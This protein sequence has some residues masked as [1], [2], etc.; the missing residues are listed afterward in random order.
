MN[1]PGAD[2][3]QGF[4][5]SQKGPLVPGVCSGG[6]VYEEG[7]TLAAL[8]ML[9]LMQRQQWA[10]AAENKQSTK[11]WPGL[12]C[13]LEIGSDITSIPPKEL[14]P[15]FIV[16]SW[17]GFCMWKHTGIPEQ[18]FTQNW[19]WNPH[20]GALHATARILPNP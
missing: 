2:C 10:D 9:Q 5:R 15:G 1:K 18:H 12:S 11:P 8:L 6:P 4:L 7:I 14:G 20:K 19:A 16:P 17:G 13:T 3:E